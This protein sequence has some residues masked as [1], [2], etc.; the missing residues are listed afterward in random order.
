[1]SGQK[2]QDMKETD[3]KKTAGFT[4]VEVIVAIAVLGLVSV[5][6]CG[7][8]ILAGRL[9]A[10]SQAVMEAQLDVRSVVET[11]M[12]EGIRQGDYDR[13][14]SV[15][16]EAERTGTDPYYKVT[17]QDRAG[18]EEPLVTVETYIHAAPE[19]GGGT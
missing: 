12:A 17:V 1:M 7:S 4:L 5:P 18:G 8:L 10:Q 11:L 6:V 15:K 13:F 3:S 14:S 19:S 16:V 2:G 9:N